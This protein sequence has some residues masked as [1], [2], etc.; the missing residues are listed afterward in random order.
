MKLNN[1]NIIIICLCALV[2]TSFGELPEKGRH[3]LKAIEDL[4]T[5]LAGTTWK[6]VPSKPLRGGLAVALTF[7]DA[8]VQPAGYHY[9]VNAHNSLTVK[10]NHGDTQLM[11]LDPDGKHLKFDHNEKHYVYELVAR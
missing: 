1:T 8:T 10:F 9:E 7:T 6:A 2:S 4:K 11:L 5:Q 3:V